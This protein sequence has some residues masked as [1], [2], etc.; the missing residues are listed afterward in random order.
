MGDHATYAAI[1]PNDITDLQM[2]SLGTI[3][4]EGPCCVFYVTKRQ[5]Y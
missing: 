3:V 4:P 2:S 5:L 1:L